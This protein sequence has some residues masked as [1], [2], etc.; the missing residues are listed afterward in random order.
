MTTNSFDHLFLTLGNWI[1]DPNSHEKP[2]YICHPSTTMNELANVTFTN[3]QTT[4]TKGNKLP[5]Y[6]QGGKL[7][8]VS[9]AEFSPSNFLNTE[10]DPE[11]FLG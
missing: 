2:D 6:L 9:D 8:P 3:S 4:N 11:I 7:S 1:E 5:D 10:F